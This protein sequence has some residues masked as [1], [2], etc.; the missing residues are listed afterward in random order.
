MRSRSD[1]NTESGYHNQLLLLKTLIQDY[2]IV[3]IELMVVI[4]VNSAVDHLREA[5]TCRS[6]HAGHG[7][8]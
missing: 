8:D 4:V 2:H 1:R 7:T 6:G 5:A 3:S